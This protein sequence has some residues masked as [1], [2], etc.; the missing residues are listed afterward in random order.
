[1]K[2]PKTDLDGHDIAFNTAST[3][4]KNDLAF[5]MSCPLIVGVNATATINEV[6]S[7]NIILI[8]ASIP[9]YTSNPLS[10]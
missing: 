4:P 5:N 10:T 8:V 9:L 6:K 1:M 3:Y 2:M 7:S